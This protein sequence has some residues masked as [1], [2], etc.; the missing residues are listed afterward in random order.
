MGSEIRIPHPDGQATDEASYGQGS[1]DQA[2]FSFDPRNH[3]QVSFHEAPDSKDDIGSCAISSGS[4]MA[5]GVFKGGLRHLGHPEPELC[6]TSGG[7]EHP[8]LKSSEV[9]VGQRYQGTV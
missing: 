8:S 6:D 7:H 3:P 5:S 9:T 4:G 2:D 1:C